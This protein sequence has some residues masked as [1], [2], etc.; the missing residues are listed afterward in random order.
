M[1]VGL[2]LRTS[3]H[4]ALTPQLQQSIRLLQMSTLELQAELEQVVLT[5]PFLEREDD[6]LDQALRLNASGAV[7][8][9]LASPDV[10]T[11][12]QGELAAPSDFATPAASPTEMDNRDAGEIGAEATWSIEDGYRQTNQDDDYAPPQV[13]A[14]TDLRHHLLEQ[15]A[16]L[17]LTQ[18]D[19]A[20]VRILIEELDD[21]GYLSLELA[22]IQAYLPAEL[23]IEQEE[24]QA[25]LHWLQHMEPAGIGARNITECLL[26]QLQQY[27]REHAA[28]DPALHQL[29]EILIRHHLDLLAARDYNKIKRQLNCT[30]ALLRDAQ[31]LIQSFDPHP[32]SQFSQEVASYVVPDVIVKKTRA[33]WQASLNTAV[34]PRLRVNQLYAQILKRH[35]LQSPQQ[36]IGGQLQE[37]KWLIKNVQ[38]RF[39]TILR[40][41]QAIVERQRAFFTHGEMAMRPLV[42]REIADTLGLH[43]STISRVTTQK[44][45]H[46]PMGIF[47]LKYFFGSHVATDAG[48]AASSTAIRALIKQLV[49]TEEPKKPLSDS[50]LADMLAEQGFMVARRTVA[51]YRELLK[52]PP[53]A[54]RKVL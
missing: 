47:E 48:G 21:N 12:N 44:Y 27:R 38:Q 26:L 11:D 10:V 16:P 1:K 46:T 39:D 29:A 13:A 31:S 34:M 30:D 28:L 51:K 2:Q 6:F 7:Q 3:Q 4:L 49:A 52:I 32:G 45:M 17:N 9:N 15:L 33:G 50:Q 36:E 20:L 35:R 18:R 53:V 54:L 24:L 43:E 19:K 42:L 22:E 14:T 25:A 40:V 5:N 37:A 8:N 23:D 41:A